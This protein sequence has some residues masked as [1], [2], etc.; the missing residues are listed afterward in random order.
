MNMELFN[1]MQLLNK[2]IMKAAEEQLWQQWLVD[3]ARMDKET[4]INF[5]DYKKK[6][7]KNENNKKLDVKEII[8]KAEEIKKIDQKSK[9]PTI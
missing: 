3:Y 4:F 7:F 5:T 1:F 2:T 9:K 6:S 8:A